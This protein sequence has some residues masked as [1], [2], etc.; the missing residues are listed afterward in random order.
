MLSSTCLYITIKV[1]STV[2]LN[3]STPL[4]IPGS[5][6]T[7]WTRRTR[8]QRWSKRRPWWDW[9]CWS[10]WWDWCCW[11][12]WT[13]WREGICWFRWCPC[14]LRPWLCTTCFVK[15]FSFV[16]L[17]TGRCVSVCRVPVVLPDPQVL[18]VTVV[19]SVS[20]DSVES[21]VSL[22]SLDPLWVPS[23]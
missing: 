1:F 23:G 11:T 18:L 12:R 20:P 10:P 8:W 7:R 17:L 6:R 3:I 14:E 13:D 2:R 4:L 21:V 16:C 19:Q 22:A 9:C 15:V 5:F